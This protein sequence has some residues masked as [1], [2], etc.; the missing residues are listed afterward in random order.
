MS[1]IPGRFMHKKF[2]WL[3]RALPVQAA[4]IGLIVAGGVLVYNISHQCA[5]YRG[6]LEGRANIAVFIRQ[7]AGTRAEEIRGRIQAMPGI[8]RLYLVTPEESLA[9]ALKDSPSLSE[10]MVTGKNPFTAY[11]L[12]Y[13]EPAL[14]SSVSRLKASLSQVSDIEEVRLDERLFSMIETLRQLG[15]LY[16]TGFVVILAGYLLIVFVMLVEKIVDEGVTARDAAARL[17]GGLAGGLLGLAIT[18][19]LMK[20]VPSGLSPLPAAA[21]WL[22]LPAGAVLSFQED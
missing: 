9:R 7:E 5:V 4:R 15:V 6:T 8:G 11:F 18:A 14:P 10:V 19:V 3:Y 2:K 1:L 21:Y 12:V 16:R 17:A 13:P 22:C 20:S